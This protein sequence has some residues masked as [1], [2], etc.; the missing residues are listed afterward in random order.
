MAMLGLHVRQLL[1]CRPWCGWLR[2]KICFW[3][4]G[5]SS[6][7]VVREVPCREAA[8]WDGMWHSQPCARSPSCCSGQERR[9][10]A[11]S[12]VLMEIN[13]CSSGENLLCPIY[14]FVFKQ[15]KSFPLLFSRSFLSAHSHHC[16]FYG[17]YTATSTGRRICPFLLHR[18]GAVGQHLGL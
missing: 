14:C 9:P 1:L 17:I 11:L 12:S 18:Y 3:E 8:R 13:C 4:V 5:E 15:T 16:L 2:P 7:S 10:R 6:G